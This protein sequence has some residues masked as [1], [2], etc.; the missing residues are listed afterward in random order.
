[1]IKTILAITAMI[2][3]ASLALAERPAPISRP[4]A[5][6]ALA[7]MTSAKR[8]YLKEKKG[9][10]C[11][12]CHTKLAPSYELKS[13]ALAQFRA[14]GG[15]QACGWWCIS[16]YDCEPIGCNACWGG[17]CRYIKPF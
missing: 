14:V 5:Q 13:D 12:E 2:S 3:L 7:A 17:Q 8:A 15:R 11:N 6:A 16:D 9:K 10:S 1:M 4:G